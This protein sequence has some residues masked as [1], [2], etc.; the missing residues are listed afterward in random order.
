MKIKNK[1]QDMCEVTCC[2]PEKID[3][4]N[5]QM[6][7]DHI[8]NMSVMFKG[9]A[10]PNRMKI[11]QALTVEEELCVCD[12]AYLLGCPVANASHHLRSLRKIG[13]VKFRKEGKLVWY[14]LD[15]EHIRDILSLAMIHQ[16]EV[17]E[18]H[19]EQ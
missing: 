16:E 14:S 17:T 11:M 13:M 1:L 19:A 9:L 2:D 12:V 3:Q 10:E 18:S 15:D 8:K 6:D 4:I 5:E 7:D